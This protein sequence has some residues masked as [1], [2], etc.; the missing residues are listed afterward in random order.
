MVNYLRI[1][2][3]RPSSNLL[4]RGFDAP[5]YERVNVRLNSFNAYIKHQ[6]RKRKRKKAFGKFRFAKAFRAIATTSCCVKARYAMLQLEVKPP[7]TV[8]GI[9]QTQNLYFFI[10]A[11]AARH[12]LC[13]ENNDDGAHGGK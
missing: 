2:G 7:F 9:V 11:Q 6:S 3:G 13:N 4:F 12:C 1:I 10:H 8:D 5:D